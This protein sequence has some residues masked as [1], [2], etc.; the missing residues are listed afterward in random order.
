[1]ETNVKGKKPNTKDAAL[2]ESVGVCLCF[3]FASVNLEI[4]VIL[5]G[6]RV[7][8]ERVKKSVNVFHWR[9]ARQRQSDSKGLS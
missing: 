6:R 9:G 4:E 3:V 8:K 7:E 1:V 5:L 2:G